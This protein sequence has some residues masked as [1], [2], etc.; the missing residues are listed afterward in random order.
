MALDENVFVAC[1]A[2]KWNHK[3]LCNTVSHERI[4]LSFSLHAHTPLLVV[5]PASCWQRKVLW[6]LHLQH[7]KLHGGQH[8]DFSCLFR[9]RKQVPAPQLLCYHD[10][11]C[12]WF[13]Q[14]CLV[15]ERWE[16]TQQLPGGRW[17][18]WNLVQGRLCSWLNIINLT[19]QVSQNK[20]LFTMQWRPTPAK[21]RWHC[22]PIVRCPKGLNQM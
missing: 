22:A 6:T 18:F 10:K 12:S 17:Y 14:S 4:S 19:R 16:F 9:Q 7:I 2:H 1:C 13:K 15:K 3:K 5:S 21:P 20:F 11:Q 8:L